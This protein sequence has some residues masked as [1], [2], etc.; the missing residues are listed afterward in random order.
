[1]SLS[2]AWLSGNSI[3]VV[4]RKYF[5]I[6]LELGEH[7]CNRLP[8]THLV[9]PPFQTIRHIFLDILSFQII[10]FFLDKSFLLY[11]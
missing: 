8:K 10:T 1:M 3:A 7:Y 4:L 5:K 6:N 9:L 2:Q 11:I